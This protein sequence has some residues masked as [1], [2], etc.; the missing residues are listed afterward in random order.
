MSHLPRRERC[1]LTAAARLW[2]LVRVRVRVRVR[3]KVSVR[4]RVR[5]KVRVR[6]RLWHLA[7]TRG[8]WREAAEPELVKRVT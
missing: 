5:V 1:R 3:V 6:V 2:H 4:V 7:T 8:L